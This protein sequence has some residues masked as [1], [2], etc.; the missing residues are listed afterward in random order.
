[1][2]PFT[3]LYLQPQELARRFLDSP[4]NASR[5]WPSVRGKQATPTADSSCR[6]SP[7]RENARG[8]ISEP[9]LP[10]AVRFL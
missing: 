9:I 2:V 4:V 1:V 8:V 10:T 5:E 7:L 6:S 3:S